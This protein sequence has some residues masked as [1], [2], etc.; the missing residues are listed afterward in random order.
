MSKVIHISYFLNP[1]CFYFKFDDELHD[2]D[3]QRLEDKISKNARDEMHQSSDKRAPI[4]VG[5]TV[6][7]YV[8]PWSKWVRSVVQCDLKSLECYEVWAIDHG[9]KIRAAYKNVVKLSADLANEHVIGVHRGSFYGVAPA[10]LVI[11]WIFSYTAD[12]SVQFIDNF[13][14]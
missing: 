2:G 5:D 14:F 1:Y 13:F 4:A 12:C 7:A 9:K 10:R 8:I 3:L 6:A 11:I